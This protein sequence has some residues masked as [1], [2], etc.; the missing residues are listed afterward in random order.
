MRVSSRFTPAN[1]SENENQ[2]SAVETRSVECGAERA[3]L[4]DE[5]DDR[6]REHERERRRGDQQ[7]ADLAHAGPQQSAQAGDVAARGEAAERREQHG[8]ERDA[9]HPLRQHVDA[10][11]GVD[12]AR[13]LS[14]ISEPSDELISRSKLMTPS[15]I[16]T[17]SISTKTRAIARV[18]PVER[19][20]RSRKSMR[21]EHRE[22][23]SAAGRSCPAA[24]RSRTRRSGSARGSSGCSTTSSADDHDVPHERRDR[25]DREV[26]VGVEDPD[27]QPVEPEQH[28]DREQ[29]AATARPS[30]RRARRE[31]RRPVNS[32]MIT[33]GA[34]DEERRDR[35]EDRRMH[36]E[37]A[38]RRAATASRRLPCSSS[39]V[40][41]GTN[42]AL[43][44]ASANR[45]RTRFGTWKAI[46]NAENG[47][48]RA[49][50]AARRRSRARGP[51]CAR[52][53]WR[54][55]RSRCCARAASS[56][57]SAG[58]E[59]PRGLSTFTS[60]L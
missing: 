30:G 49:E 26:V 59:A 32:G 56:V 4:V 29:H 2:N 45:L 47:A 36:P 16:V 3:V 44:A 53:R 43:S 19:A 51:R 9:E 50:V 17:G 22:R 58:P 57:S 15:P 52:A 48:A 24:R 7:Q 10:E 6:R 34:E 27:E 39:S 13:R 14:E 35:A 25:R 18:A 11:R 1:G 38:S 28:H 54:S 40:K 33:P 21:A 31:R 12:R 23:P 55:R 37:Q 41:T 20:L 60:A 46:V 8:R 5:R 42:A